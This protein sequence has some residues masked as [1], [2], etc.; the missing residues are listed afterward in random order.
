MI[1][2]NKVTCSTPDCEQF[3]KI[4]HKTAGLF[5]SIFV[6]DGGEEGL[7]KHICDMKPLY[8]FPTKD[9]KD[10]LCKKCH[11]REVKNGLQ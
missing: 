8:W 7:V 1:T 11:D 5:M 4:K 10:V 3:M 2:E 6:Y 9:K